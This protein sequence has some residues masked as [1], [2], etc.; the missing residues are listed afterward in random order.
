MLRLSCLY[1]LLDGTDTI[2]VEHLYAALALWEYA[3]ASVAYV[4]GDATGD[5]TVDVLLAALRE[6]YPE[7]LTRWQINDDIFAKHQRTEAIARALRVLTDKGA[8]QIR[9]DQN[10]GGRP[11]ET[12][13]YRPECGESGESGESP[14][15]Y[16][17]LAQE[18]VKEHRQSKDEGVI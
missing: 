12:I 5:P 18:A 17:R 14:Q 16:L 13:F 8:I 2:T 15:S 6:R 4:F 9:K 1:A 7:G 10:T 11:S 3:E